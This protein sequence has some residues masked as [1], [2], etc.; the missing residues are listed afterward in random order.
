ML[1]NLNMTGK[2]WL[3][4]GVFIIGFVLTTVLGQIQGLT[5]ETTLRNTAEALFPAAQK[6]QES[7]A[8]F[9]RGIKSFSDAVLTQDSSALDRAA[10]DG[11]SVVESL[12]AVATIRGLPGARVSQVKQLSASIAQLFAD[13]Q[14]TYRGVLA[15]PAGMNADIQAHMRDLASSTDA[16]KAELQ[17]VKTAFSKDLQNEL[18]GLARR[19]AAQQRLSWALLV[20]TLIVAGVIVNLTIRRSIAGPIMHVID[21]VTAAAEDALQSSSR[22]AASGQGVARDA[23]HQASYIQETSASLEEISATTR[24]NADR[25]GEADRLM[26]SAR[27][28]VEEASAAMNDLQSSMQE[29]SKSS[30]QVSAVLKSID[31]IAFHTNILALNAAVEA[32]RAGEAGAGFS[33]VADEVRSLAQRAAEAAGR[34]AEIIEKTITDVSRGEALVTQAHTAF[35][36]VSTSFV[37]GSKVVTQIAASSREQAR[38]VGQIGEAIMRIEKVTQN[39]VANAQETAEA[40]AGMTAQ[41]ENTRKHLHKLVAIVGLNKAA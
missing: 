11:R 24:E 35:N 20:G 29:I 31:E 6:T 13:A 18:T 19:S 5:T 12:N 3:S 33:V 25:A 2:I 8:G 4:I 41:M 21:G 36:E 37:S 10:E 22:M 32:A 40:A 28:T 16:L 9:D 14:N 15:N 38:G 30:K 34:S 39:N 26:Q 7:A 23:Q 27:Q 17:Q 1:R